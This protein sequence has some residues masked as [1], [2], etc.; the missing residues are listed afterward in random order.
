MKR[1]V[2]FILFFVVAAVGIA[3]AVL[4]ANLVHLNYYFGASQAPLSLLLVLAIAAG[5]VLGIV[6]SLGVLMRM[7]R[8]NARLRKAVDLSRKEIANLRAIPLRDK[9]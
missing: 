7:K 5:A 9:H 8:D 2:S 6:A 4:N 1:I 3:F